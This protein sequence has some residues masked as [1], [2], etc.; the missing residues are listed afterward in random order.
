V[1]WNLLL[2]T[3]GSII[4]SIG[5][6]GIIIHSNFIPG[7]IFGVALLLEDKLATF[8]PA[9][10]FFLLNI[11]LFSI[12][13][14]FVGKKFFYYS[15]YGMLV[16]TAATELITLDF[17]INEQIYAAVAGGLICG[18]GSGLVLRSLGSGGG[19]D[20]IAIALYTKFNI[21][22]GKVYLIFNIILFA[23]VIKFY[24]N[25]IVVASVILT[26]INSTT[27]DRIISL[28]NQRKIVYV[29]SDFSEKIAHVLLNDMSQRATFINGQ[30]AYSGQDTKILMTIT[31]N[32]QLKKLENLIFNIDEHALFIVE[33]SFNVIGST[34]GKRKMY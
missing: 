10:W 9:T 30:G 33:N 28:F 34:I 20:I 27:V 16:I 7:G 4:Y 21:G 3:A 32:L 31:N 15:L 29:I 18:I 14:F 13:W 6:N 24:D 1:S 25:D 22:V 26:Y 11:P 2:I 5:I 17:N 8:S 23:F 12:G 19:L